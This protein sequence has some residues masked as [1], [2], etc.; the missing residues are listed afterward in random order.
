MILDWISTPVSEDEPAGPDLWDADDSAY[1]EYY[2]S[3]TSRLPE[4]H[5]YAKIGLLMG[6][7]D[8]LPDTIFDPGSVALADE[9]SEIDALV[10]RS[11]D[12]RLLTLRAQW[13]MLAGDIKAVTQSVEA[14]ADVLEAMP[15]E[16]HPVL[17][18]GASSRL[19]PI[20]D[21]TAVGAMILPLR[22]LDIGGTGT[23]RRRMMVARS[24]MTPHDGENDLSLDAMIGAMSKSKEAVA[25]AHGYLVCFKDALVRIEIACLSNDIPHTPQITTLKQEIDAVL[26]VIAEGDPDLAKETA[27][28]DESAQT[29]T[30]TVGATA[31]TPTIATK[32]K[33]HDEAR[34]R[35]VAVETYFGRHEP[36]SAAVL[37]VTQS[38]LLIGKSLIDALDILMPS[39][40]PLAKIEFISDNGFK[41]A[42]AQLRSL[43]DEV[44][45]E[46]VAAPEPQPEVAGAVATDVGGKDAKMLPDAAAP[47]P[48]VTE[49]VFR[50]SDSE[51]AGAQIL[52]VESYFRAV[53]KSSPIPMLLSRARSYIGKDFE[54]IL[55]ELVPKGDF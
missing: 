42:H 41:L 48:S 38:R 30:P 13:C 50:V 37:L 46:D 20:N 47:R 16:A 32:V 34:R 3:A 29:D 14:M 4:P 33:S 18:G 22:Y 43:A 8:K 44:L 15:N 40:A 2:F 10:K 25:E 6:G 11:R 39:S 31:V 21:L 51:A 28:D 35:L 9:L 55:K 26:A 1:S 7:G 49:T 36:S 17:D 24:E 53:E 52:A 23:S 45:V 5:D 27:S 19:E 54:S 12:L